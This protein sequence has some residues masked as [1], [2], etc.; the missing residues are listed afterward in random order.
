MTIP[1]INPG[2]CKDSFSSWAE[3]VW[4]NSATWVS[5]R[6]HSLSEV[7][8]LLSKWALW[9][10]LSFSSEKG[11]CEGIKVTCSISS[12]FVRHAEWDFV[13]LYEKNQEYLWKFCY[14]YNKRES[15]HL[16]TFHLNRFDQGCLCKL[17]IF[18]E[19]FCEIR[20]KLAH[21][22]RG[23]KRAGARI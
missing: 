15:I 17:S 12:S 7:T 4:I 2:F 23:W 19:Y 18:V 21:E 22:R 5:T 1:L 16:F 3:V 10:I 11:P 9:K 20:T 14:H 8:E 6:G 13:I